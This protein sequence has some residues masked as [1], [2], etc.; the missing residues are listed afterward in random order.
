MASHH[1]GQNRNPLE[2]HGETVTVTT[3][4]MVA[5]QFEP[6]LNIN[7]QLSHQKKSVMLMS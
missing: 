1:F 7:D 5:S 6:Q 4:P 2:K 3:I